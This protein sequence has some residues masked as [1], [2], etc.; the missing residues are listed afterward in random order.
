MIDKLSFGN[1]PAE[2]QQF[3]SDPHL[4]TVDHPGYK[5]FLWLNLGGPIIARNTDEFAA[6]LCFCVFGIFC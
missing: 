1:C 2:V 4:F 6:D 3:L 5:L